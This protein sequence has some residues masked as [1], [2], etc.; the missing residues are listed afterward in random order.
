MN[1][2]ES[3][4]CSYHAGVSQ[5]QTFGSS[6]Q[7][8]ALCGVH[9]SLGGCLYNHYGHNHLPRS[10]DL[11]R[12]T[13]FPPV[14]EVFR[15]HVFLHPVCFSAREDLL[16]HASMCSVCGVGLLVWICHKYDSSFTTG[17]CRLGVES[18]RLGLQSCRLG[19]QSCRLGGQSCLI[20]CL[21][22]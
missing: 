11:T 8:H 20:H 3:V 10:V 5:V 2:S 13:G 6:L 9:C 15:V 18:C 19:V 1:L 4:L 21:R 16:L 17:N 12:L 7:A 14:N 22:G